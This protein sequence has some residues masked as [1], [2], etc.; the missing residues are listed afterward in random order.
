MPPERIGNSNMYKI[1]ENE[2]VEGIDGRIHGPVV[3]RLHE[4]TDEISGVQSGIQ[5]IT[6]NTSIEAATK[7]IPK[8]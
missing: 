4:F 5:L 8:E 7:L 1:P 3:V 6:I 2:A